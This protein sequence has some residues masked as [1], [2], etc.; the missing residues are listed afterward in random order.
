MASPTT[1]RA[2]LGAFGAAVPASMFAAGCPAAGRPDE[3][4]GID[5]NAALV[6]ELDAFD[7]WTRRLE[8]NKLST[9]QEWNDW[10]D[11]MHSLYRRVD[12][13]P[14]TRENVAVKVRAVRS[15][16]LDEDMAVTDRADDDTVTRLAMHI[17]RAL[18]E[19]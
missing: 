9:E 19:G 16:H 4:S 14:P 18:M 8:A 5:P 3:R 13:L 1:R 12:A 10:H 17:V 7:D 2:V 11:Q 6:A 15:I